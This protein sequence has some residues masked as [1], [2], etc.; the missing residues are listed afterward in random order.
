MIIRKIQPML[1]LLPALVPVPAPMPNA[2]A[3]ATFALLCLSAVWLFAAPA[4]AFAAPQKDAPVTEAELAADIRILANDAFE[5]RDPGTGGEARTIAYLVGQW[6]AIGLQPLDGSTTPWLQPVPLREVQPLDSKAQFHLGGRNISLH[7][8]EMIL[9]TGL[10]SAKVDAAPLIFVGHGVDGRGALDMDVRG[11]VALL[12]YSD[13]PFS[14]KA[15]SLRKRRQNL[16]AAGAAAII[17][18]AN[19]NLPWAALR[20]AF[21]SPSIGLASQGDAAIT[22]FVTMRGFDTLMEKAGHQGEALRAAA[23]SAGFRGQDLPLTVDLEAQAEQRSIESHN[24]IARLPG[25]NPDGKAL[26]F[27]G[28]WDHLGICRPDDEQDRIC[29]GAVDNASG[30]ASMAAIA[31]RL[32]AGPRPDR[33]IIFLAT[34]AE[35]R[36]LLGAHHFAAN[37]LVPLDQIT[38]IFNLDTV[39]VAPR[40]KP[41]AVIGRG[42]PAYDAAIR[43]VATAMG[44]VMDDDDEADDFRDRQDGAAFTARDVPAFMVGGSFSDMTLLQAFL[45]GP[46]HQ[47]EDEASATMQ[48]GGAAEDADLHIALARLFADR[49]RWSGEKRAARPASPP[50]PAR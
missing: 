1:A 13:A 32:A 18:I 4:A 29:N 40:G 21:T 36:G 25:A 10:P 15:Q 42:R 34:T 27:M 6:S 9:R 20:D 7:E 47:A 49:S 16:A 5:G 44:R 48:L 46:Y 43:S 37:P 22:A 26:I 19:E 38:A 45:S 35:E 39:A 50:R 12:L 31:R 8:D 41:V 11:K 17:T 2:R 30:L 23:T 28:H 14:K 24:I 3:S 33:D